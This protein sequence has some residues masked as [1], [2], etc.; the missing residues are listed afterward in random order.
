MHGKLPEP[1]PCPTGWYPG[2]RWAWWHRIRYGHSQHHCILEYHETGAHTCECGS[3]PR[4]IEEW[5]Q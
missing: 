4:W 3:I 2:N 1:G 5:E